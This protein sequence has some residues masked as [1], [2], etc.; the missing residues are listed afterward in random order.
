MPPSKPRKLPGATPPP[1]DDRVRARIAY[2]LLSIFAGTVGLA[3][4]MSPGDIRQL[5]AALI[6]GQVCLLGAVMRSY[7]D[8]RD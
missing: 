5:G 7:F 2:S 4:V 1:S 8:D 3:F 6:A